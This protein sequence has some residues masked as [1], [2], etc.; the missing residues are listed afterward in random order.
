MS[1]PFRSS[2]LVFCA[3]ACVAQ[4]QPGTLDTD[5]GTQGKAFVTVSTFDEQDDP[6]A[7]VVQ[8]DGRILVA[9]YNSGLGNV[10][11]GF[12][13]R[14]MP[15]GD[16]DIT[17]G[18]GGIVMLIPPTGTL[19]INCMALQPDGK[20]ILGGAQGTEPNTV[21]QEAWIARLNT[22]GLLDATFGV[23]GA[24]IMP[25]SSNTDYVKNVAVASDGAVYGLVYSGPPANAPACL[26]R[27]LPNGHMD[28]GFSG[29]GVR[30]DLFGGNSGN[31]LGG[32]AVRVDGAALAA[33]SV[34]GSKVCAV[35]PNGSFDTSF[36]TGGVAEIPPGSLSGSMVSLI[37]RTD[38]NILVS[39]SKVNAAPRMFHTTMLLSNGVP[40]GQFGSGGL[41]EFTD[42]GYVL[43]T[44]ATPAVLYPDGRYLVAWGKFDQNAGDRNVALTWFTPDGAEHEIGTTT[45]DVGLGT[46]PDQD[47]PFGL[48][49][50]P[51]GDLVVVVRFVT[52]LGTMAVLRFN[53]APL[54]TGLGGQHELND[55]RVFPVPADAVLNVGH[56]EVSTTATMAVF[57][58]LGQRLDVQVRR[59]GTSSTLD[60]SGLAA[61]SYLLVVSDEGTTRASRFQVM[62]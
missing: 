28:N 36:G 8:P 57:D 19:Q 27:L 61:G 49:L 11:R 47:T 56:N 5:F 52:E 26:V 34:G 9:G 39:G 60:V 43:G 2:L 42:P 4:A 24:R 54:E 51:D 40:D 22:N 41:A 32:L 46:D 58:L 7:I 16:L 48:A 53:G 33:G 6:R 38:G 45:V 25:L 37:I 55:L 14:L 23:N 29:D 31:S 62:R 12:V 18:N 1:H 17:F 15:D 35:L 21:T 10:S 44:R 30:C 59:G 3:F 13:M 50:A 20:I